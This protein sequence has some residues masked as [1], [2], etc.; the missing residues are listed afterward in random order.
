MRQRAAKKRGMQQAIGLHIVDV[1][2][3]A[4]QHARVFKAFDRTANVGVSGRCHA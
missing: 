3:K 2:P 1:L 4:A